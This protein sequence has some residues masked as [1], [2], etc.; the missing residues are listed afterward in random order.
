MPRINLIRNSVHPSK[1]HLQWQLRR[2]SLHKPPA[3]AAAAPLLGLAEPM[4][5]RL[6]IYIGSI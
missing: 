2:F 5:A 4:A 6:T 1:L 3:K